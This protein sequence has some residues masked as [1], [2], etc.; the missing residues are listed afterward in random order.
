MDRVRRVDA[1]TRKECRKMCMRYLCN[2][3][4]GNGYVWC[5]DPL[6][7]VQAWP[8]EA[9]LEEGTA[10]GERKWPSEPGPG[11]VSEV[12]IVIS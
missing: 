4:D 1:G 2:K 3:G 8:E 5:D 10:L 9:V 6:E 11:W 12:V 7:G